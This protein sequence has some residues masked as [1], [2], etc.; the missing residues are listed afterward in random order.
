MT[1]LQGGDANV[2]L[3]NPN[4]K[5]RPL[6]VSAVNKLFRPMSST[7]SSGA[8]ATNLYWA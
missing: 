5:P 1:N 3:L 2:I 4:I 8:G 6:Q 7:D